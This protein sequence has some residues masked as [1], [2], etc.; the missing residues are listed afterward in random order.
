MI[1]NAYLLLFGLILC[2]VF[3]SML[4]NSCI[5]LSILNSNTNS[6]I[7]GGSSSHRRKEKNDDDL[8]KK[9]EVHKKTFIDTK[10][11]HVEFPGDRMF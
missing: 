8:V 10:E 3:V 9:R 11:K 2:I 6:T 4:D 7:S 5:D 1:D